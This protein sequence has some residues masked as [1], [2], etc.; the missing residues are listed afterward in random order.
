MPDLN[1]KNLERLAKIV[2]EG[3]VGVFEYLVELEEKLDTILGRVDEK[4][5]DAVDQVESSKIN[6]KDL[7]S[8]IRGKDGET[9]TD[10]KLLLLIQPLIQKPENGKTP[11]KDELLALIRPLLPS[12]VT[13]ERLLKL[14]TPLV[15]VPVIPDISAITQASSA[16]AVEKLTPMIPKI[17]DIEKDIP[18]LGE[19]IRDALELLQDDNRLD[20]SAIKGLEKLLKEIFKKTNQPMHVAGPSGGGRSVQALDLSPRLDG[21]TKTFNIPAV[22]R[23]IGVFGTSSP[24]TFR[25]SV[26]FT[27]TTQS[28]TFTSQIDETTVLSAGQTIT[29]LYAEN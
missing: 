3:S 23:I 22:W 25:E 4:V 5:K 2:D 12:E 14:I 7:V 6:I 24:F 16:L 19:P 8:E 28:I 18:K 9:P 27:W 10:E 21:S 26:D 1:K 11:T 15:P 13:D 17:E 29:I 20:A